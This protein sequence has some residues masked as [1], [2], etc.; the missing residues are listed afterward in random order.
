MDRDGTVLRVLAE[1]DVSTTAT[2]ARVGERISILALPFPKTDLI[3]IDPDGAS[4]I[5]IRA[6]RDSPGT[7][8]AIR[9][10]VNG[11][12]M[13]HRR[14]RFDPQPIVRAVRDS[15]HDAYARDFGFLPPGQA[16][17]AARNHIDVP[18]TYPPVTHAVLADDGSA[19]L[20]WENRGAPT[21]EWLVLDAT[22]HHQA[23]ITAPAHLVIQTVKQDRVWGALPDA[24]GVPYLIGFDIRR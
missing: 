12:S 7:L 1:R 23:T 5:H 20:R 3:A 18:A 4:L 24:L 22:G 9:L 8:E 11:D 10:S 15:I 19:W 13:Y 6:G 21:A 2:I 14:Y 16:R 17:E